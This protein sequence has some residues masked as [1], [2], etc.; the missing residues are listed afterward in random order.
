M[1]E[2][3]GF[4][5]HRAHLMAVAYRMLGSRGADAED[6]VQEAWLRYASADRSAIRD[7]RAW[8]TRTTARICLDVLRSA[9]V[10]REAYVGP[11]LPEPVV[12]RLPGPGG[13]ASLAADPAD[14][15][16][17]SDEVSYALL[18]VLERLTAE[19]RVALVLHD[20]FR[21]GFEEIAEVLGTT[22][23]AARQLASRARR[24]VTAKGVPRHR[25]DRTEQRRVI[26]AFV[27]A[28]ESGDLDAL[29]AVLAP[30]VVA[31]GDGGGVLPAT[32]RPV[33]GAVQVARFMAGLLRRAVNQAADLVVEPVA[34]NG[35]LGLL[36][37]V[38]YP[39]GERQRIAMAF[40]I[41]EGRITGIFNQLNPHK[42]THVPPAQPARALPLPSG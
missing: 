2:L 20:V 15:A 18:V 4:E 7:V 17:R 42:L 30:D 21:V 27:A 22:P 34:V 6:V 28:A 29:V 5:E 11:W 8:L 41:A 9:R 26:R 14:R 12:S 10:R 36:I 38:A 31:M 3:T 39:S 33:E 19:Q 23:V 1:D 13:A 32:R 37:E 24:A 40:A 25:A 35:D 16:A